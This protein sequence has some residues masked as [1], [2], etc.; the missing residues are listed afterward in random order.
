MMRATGAKFRMLASYTSCLSALEDDTPPSPGD[1]EGEERCRDM[2]KGAKVICARLKVWLQASG[3]SEERAVTLFLQR[4][5]VRGQ[6]G[7]CKQ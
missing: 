7:A 2:G 4:K 1:L 3:F 6:R 5:G